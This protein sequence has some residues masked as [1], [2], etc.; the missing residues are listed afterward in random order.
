MHLEVISKGQAGVATKPPLLFVHGAWH[1]AWCWDQGFLD[2]CVTR[3]FEVH[4]LSLRGHCG[5][6]GHE[7]LRWNRIK[8]Y[9]EDVAAVAAQLSS[10]PV[11]IGHSMGGFVVQK[12]VER[13]AAKAAVLIASVPPHG[14]F[15][16]LFRLLL[17]DP[18]GVLKVNATWSLKPVVATP[19]KARSLFFSPTMPEGQALRYFSLLQDESYLGFLDMLLFDLCNPA[20]VKV[21]ILVLGGADDII[22]PSHVTE[23]VAKSYHS[24]PIIFP[25]MPHDLMLEAGSVKVTDT[26]ID[27][28]EAQAFD[29]SGGS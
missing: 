9:V 21:P 25:G 12:Y 20:A 27:W 17:K 10:P 4:A 2:R 22:F 18:L 16:A 6:A 19:E 28:V 1:G 15:G 7:R 5:S 26:I 3:G 29:R 24:R 8:D 23:A 14:A 11:V 13:H